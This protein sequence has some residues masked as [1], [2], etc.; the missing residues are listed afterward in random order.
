MQ[1]MAIST[2]LIS[3]DSFKESVETSARRVILFGTI[4]T[5]ILDTTPTVTPPTTHV[6]TTSTP[7][8]IPTVSPIVSPSPDYTPA[9]PDYSPTSDTESDSSKDPSPDHIPPLPA[10]SPFLSLIDDSSDNDTPDTPPSPTYGTSFTK[11]T[12]ST[13]RS[14]VA[15][16]ALHSLSE[17]SSYFSLDALSDSSFGHSSLD[18]SSS[19]QLCSSVPSIPY[20]STTIT[21]RPSHASS[22]GPSR[23]RS[24]SFD[25]ATDLKDCS[26]ESSESFIQVEIDKCIAY[27]DALRAEGIDARIVVESVAQ[28][29]VEI[30]ARGLIK[31]RVDRFM[32]PIVSD[33]IPEPAQ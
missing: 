13:Q 10:T 1:V 16:G 30:S 27:A 15:S 31:V 7:I 5:I 14:P 4:P 29:E 12:L 8:E 32:H 17:T 20:S 22:A 28:E 3:L 18:H 33:D 26:N 19:H 21:E 9:S 24:R 23:K 25:S 11:I 6:D 2:I